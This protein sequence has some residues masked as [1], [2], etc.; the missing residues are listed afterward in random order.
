MSA[1]AVKGRR[2]AGPAALLAGAAA[3]LRLVAC[4]PAASLSAAPAAAA[5]LLV[6][7][8]AA[9]GSGDGALRWPCGVASAVPGELLV[10]DAFRPRLVLFREASPDWTSERVIPLAGP[11]TG[12]AAAGERYVVATRGPSALFAVDRLSWSL[13]PLPLPEG[14]VL[15]ALA[16]LPDGTVLAYDAAG[17][18]VL[19]IAAN[20]GVARRIP[21]PGRVRAIAPG[22][23]GGI[24]AAYP[25]EGRVARLGPDGAVSESWTVPGEGPIRAWPSGLAADRGGLLV[26]DRHAGRVVALDARGAAV[27]SG[28]RAGRE[29]GL[30][31]LPAA[32]TLM[33][34]GRVAVA[35]QGNGRVQIFR[36]AD[37]AGTGAPA[38]GRT[39]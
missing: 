11:P 27:G 19:A 17:N 36:R 25:D 37:R 35:D 21:A 5:P 34:D 16:A 7:E 29:A 39:P 10:A 20:G 33:P 1:M 14:T 15:G 30:L 32:L 8:S 31:W 38:A 6:W 23:D 26:L 12:I 18:Q 3:A 4:A 28:A 2:I 9:Y 24:D 22:P 13:R